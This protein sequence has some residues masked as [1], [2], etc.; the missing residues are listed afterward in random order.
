MKLAIAILA[1]VALC[2][3]APTHVKVDSSLYAAL[4]NEGTVDIMVILRDEVAPVVKAANMRYFTSSAEK[5][6]AMVSELRQFTQ[7]SQRKVLSF[8]N[9]QKG[10][11][12][13]KEFWITN[14]ISVRGATQPL[15]EALAA[16]FT[17]HIAEIRKAVV[18]HLEDTQ[19][20]MAPA[21]EPQELAW[22]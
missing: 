12:K 1:A 17:D 11:A 6:T 7:N 14:R 21:P 5:T 10:E 2:H 9:K 18:I 15:I 16:Q 13:V 3:A 8:L 19:P 4:K 22:G 20:V